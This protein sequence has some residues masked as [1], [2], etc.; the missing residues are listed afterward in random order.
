MRFWQWVALA[1]RGA[2]F[3]RRSTSSPLP[4]SSGGVGFGLG[5]SSSAWSR[6]R[7]AP[8]IRP[9]KRRPTQRLPRAAWAR[10]RRVRPTTEP[11]PSA[12]RRRLRASIFRR[13]KPSRPRGLPILE[14]EVA[15]N[16][17]VTAEDVKSYLKRRRGEAFSPA[18]LTEDVR[19]LYGLRLLRRH[20]GR[21]RAAGPGRACCASSCASAR[22]S[23]PSRFEGNVEIDDDELLGSHRGQAQ[24]R[25]EPPGGA[26][27]VSRR[28]AT[29][30]RR[31]ATSSPR[32]TSEVVPH[33]RTTRSRSSSRSREHEP[34][35]R[36]ARHLHRQRPASRARSCAP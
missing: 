26:P 32:S 9:R 21:P 30:T 19:E 34:G 13:P 25:P 28:S 6:D 27:R 7:C 33:R 8:P 11:P 16:R 35:Q 4:P 29:C 3:L 14:I 31:R 22:A 12:S 2:A 15:G 17:R 24:H 20:R 18:S 10:P 23:A 1:Q 36:P 5:S